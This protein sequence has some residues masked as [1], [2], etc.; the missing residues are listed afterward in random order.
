MNLTVIE[1]LKPTTNAPYVLRAVAAWHER[2]R[3]RRHMIIAAALRD[4]AEWRMA[5]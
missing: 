5:A 4:A 2:R 1:N 3:S